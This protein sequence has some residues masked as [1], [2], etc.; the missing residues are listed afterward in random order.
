M[1]KLNKLS[2]EKSPFCCRVAK[3]GV[4][5]F[6]FCMATA[7]DKNTDETETEEALYEKIL[8]SYVDN[9]V[10]PTYGGMAD[11]AMAMMKLCE[12]M[13]Y[14]VSQNFINQA[15]EKWRETRLYWE[16]SEAFL[17][18]P[19]EYNS[20]DPHLDSWPLDKDRLDQVLKQPDIMDIDASYARTNFGASLVGFHAMEYVLFRDGTSRQS[21]D[22]SEK[23]LVYLKAI[24]RV[25]AEDC[26]LLEGGWSGSGN[27]STEKKNVLA[28]ADLSISANFGSEMKNA[29]KSGSRYRSVSDAI[30]DIIEGCKDI[31][32]EVGNSKIADPVESGNV[33]DVE[34]WYSW[35]SINDFVNNIVSIQNSYYGSR[36]GISENSLSKLMETKYPDLDKEIKA[37]IENAK[38]KIKAIGDPFRNHLNNVTGAEEAI[39]ACDQLFYSLQKLKSNI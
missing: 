26:I 39:R 21:S 9:M 38:T 10:I 8:T 28:E 24:A 1:S 17:F 29:G 11:E 20:L 36:E 14:P 7:C 33:L 37:N 13:T 27:L 2:K 30:E 23:E 35:N 19:A 25:L 31:A 12:Q 5:V 6:V 3:W 16:Q 34:S 4:L 22:I 32:D 15:C 18:G